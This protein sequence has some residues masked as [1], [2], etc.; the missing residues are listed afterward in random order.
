MDQ[1]PN[2]R[3]SSKILLK[4]SGTLPENGQGIDESD[5]LEVSE[6]MH[7]SQF[8]LERHFLLLGFFQSFQQV[9]V[10]SMRT[11]PEPGDFVVLHYAYSSIVH[12]NSG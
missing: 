4:I 3:G 12:V 1:S 5:G 9:V 8:F 6:L 7:S 11:N 2:R 10:V